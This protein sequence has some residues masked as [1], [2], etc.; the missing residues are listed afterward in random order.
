MTVCIHRRRLLCGVG[1]A[2]G[3]FLAPI[4]VARPAPLR[5]GLPPVFLD[6]QAAF[7]Q[8]WRGYL[9]ERTGMPVQFVQ[10]ASYREIVEPLLDGGLEMAWLCGYPY[11]HAQAQLRLLAAP[12]YQGRSE[13]Q[14]YLI[15][16]KDQPEL[17]HLED[18]GGRVFAFSDPNSFSGY[19]Y[20]RYR[21][22]QAGQHPDHFFRRHFF[23]WSHR[24][25]AEAVASGL[26]DGGAMAGYVWDTLA[27]DHPEITARTKVITRSDSHGFPP[28]VARQD[29]SVA[30]FEVVQ[31]VFTGM[32]RDE[33]GR[34][35]LARLNLDGFAVADAT[36]Y[37]SIARIAR[38]TGGG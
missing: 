9:S 37:A 38:E 26:A 25:V 23:T 20:P 33:Q 15:V 27:R 16:R 18:L 22:Q 36:Q 19:L 13:Y 14:S 21:L 11:V 5:I 32:H 30:R 6:E 28:F 3:A 2:L 4:A 31:S 8:Q 10:R 7:L 35:L 17:R 34:E 29:L 24:K 1:L 12:L